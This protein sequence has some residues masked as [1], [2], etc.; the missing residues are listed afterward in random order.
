MRTGKHIA[1]NQRLRKQSNTLTRAP[2][3][4]PVVISHLHWHDMTFWPKNQKKKKNWREPHLNH[5]WT[6]I[7]L[8]LASFDL[9]AIKWAK[10][11]GW[12]ISFI[13]TVIKVPG[14]K[15]RVFLVISDHHQILEGLFWKLTVDCFFFNFLD[16]VFFGG[17]GFG[18]API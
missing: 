14:K 15:M 8:F 11:L 10:L 1:G 12:S 13:T 6:N 3:I 17:C 5:S 7:C 9:G 2:N 4:K 18:Q 16:F